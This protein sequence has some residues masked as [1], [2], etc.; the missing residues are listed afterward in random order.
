MRTRTLLC[1]CIFL[2]IA[3]NTSLLAQTTW[4]EMIQ[5]PNAN[6]Y[7][8]QN[9]FNNELG[10]VPYRKGLGIKQ[11]RRWEYYWQSRVDEKGRFPE[12][13]HA[14][15][16]MEHYYNT[17]SNS[18]NYIAGSG[19]WS[20]LGPT[21]VPNNGTGQ[22][23]GNGRLNCI[24]FHPTDANT[25][26]V[27]APAGGVWKTT[28][29]GAT[30]TQHI[31][32]LTRLGVSSIIVHPTNHNTI[33]I[34]T[35]DRDGGD[36]PGYG[37]WRSLDGGLTWAAHNNG[38]GNR[39]INELIMDPTNANVM[40]A[41]ASNGRIYRTT[42]G[43][44]NWNSTFIGFN[45][46]DI[47]M[48]PT[49]S[50]IIYASGTR[51]F[52]STDGGANFNQITNG[53]P[54]GVQRIAL[55]VSPNQPNWVYLLAGGG[56]GLVGIYRSTNS[57]ASYSTR[58]TTPNIL[59]YETDGSGTASQAWYDLVI[60]ADPTDAN[61]IYTGGVNLWKS[62]NGG[63]TMQCASY[64]VGP[65]G[66]PTGNVEGVHAD[67]HVLEFS[68]HNN[69]LYN[70]NDGGIY[71]TTNGGTNWTDI[72]D[73]LAI[74]QIY[75][76]GISQQTIDRAINGYQDNGT[77][78][79]TGT[80]FS[81]EI[82]GD[83]MEC[84][85]DPTDDNYVYGSLYYG[86][87]RRS[88][89]GGVNF[90]WQNIA[91]S[92]PQGGWVTPFKLDPNNANRMLTGTSEI[93]RNN[94]VR[95]TNNWTQISNFGGGNNF[96][97]LAIAASN[98]DVVYA[99][100]SN[101][102]FYRSNNATAGSPTWTTLSG[103]LPA[104]G[105]VADIEIDPNDPT[106]LFIAL[107]NN[108]YES[109]NSGGSWTDFSGTLPNISLNTIVLDHS[110]TAIGAIY[111]GMDAGVYYREN[112]LT[113]WVMYST[114]LPNVEVTELE[115]HYNTSTCRNT[116]YAAT[117]GQGLFKS[118][119]K[120]SSNVAAVACFEA[121]LTAACMGEPITFT[122]IS[123]HAPTSWT[124][125]VTPNTVSYI[126]GTNANSQNPQIV[127]NA[128]GSYT[129]QLNAT[130]ATGTGIETKTGYITVSSA[131][132]ASSFNDDF[133]SYGLCATTNNCA[134]T[135]CALGALWM[136]LTNGT[137]DN[138]DWRVDDGGTPSAGTGPSVDYNPGT[139]AGNYA[140]LEA[141]NG[142][143]GQTAI[144]ESSCIQLNQ[145]YNFIFAY[146]MFG[147]NMGSL[148]V[149]INAGGVWT[150][151]LRPAISGDQGNSWQT[152]SVDLSAY[153]GQTIKLRIRG[154]TGSDFESDMA[155]DDIRMEPI[156][157]LDSKL[158]HLS[159]SC[160]DNGQN[161]V[162]WMMA[163]DQFEGEFRV[164]KYHNQEWVAIGAIPAMQ[165]L[166]YQF[167]DP[168]PFAGENLYRLAM[169]DLSGNVDYSEI[170]AT[171][172]AT[173]NHSFTVFPN[174]FKQEIS[175]Q[176]HSDQIS[177]LPYR[178]TN[179]LGQDLRTG[180]FSVQQGVNT[181]QL[182]MQDWAQGVYLLHVEGKMIKLVKQ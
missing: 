121:S 23:N 91:N 165:Q 106:H 110:N 38:M 111:V 90:G 112:S 132:V 178:I 150:Q 98:S 175:L 50:S 108:I 5:D 34:A 59:G 19:N 144:L 85:I 63:S 2:G 1:L 148:H 43:G 67:Q 95:N 83:G 27:G 161:L 20:L 168:N 179:L 15:K 71:F 122:D 104:G 177:T 86:N 145:N 26:Y 78:M 125:T 81:T 147:G 7:D 39:T 13:G 79:S 149:D 24:A 170:I 30:W 162:N 41:A 9:A 51:V 48:H 142:C 3:V 87:I 22:L 84:I 75:K 157:I 70:G 68:P 31:A 25:I 180:Q 176:F 146:H 11:Y 166:N 94:D 99:S 96:T 160:E 143:T 46:K 100:R 109:T 115:I 89:D 45:M 64:W 182:P 88:T 127:F 169:V 153:N 69:T 167:I 29:N 105:V 14:L 173:S 116:L 52:R 32:G 77:A 155:I 140:Y 74:A 158:K 136:N 42:D 58:T 37:V 35:G 40:V 53:V 36:A 130:N 62:T 101:G 49:N 12:P 102:A 133:E 154:I 103:N 131:T 156:T 61:I 72:S 28:D 181:F 159:A 44:A 92:I 151:D 172:C 10:N 123:A 141:S 80:Q 17:H 164:E 134:A 33:Y 174:P 113:D 21:P 57:G 16:E 73:G 137:D 124:W 47:A 60:A 120:A 117:Y 82:G 56:S 76:I 8:I 119:L 93:Y 18:R 171:T 138:I 54:G 114:G 4:Q 65:S 97:D 118:D 6:F 128:A 139:A 107:G 135:T 163:N 126:G 66:S 152:V 55:A 129:I